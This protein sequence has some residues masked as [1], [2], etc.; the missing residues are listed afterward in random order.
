LVSLTVLYNWEVVH[1]PLSRSKIKNMWS[2]TSAPRGARTSYYRD[3]YFLISVQVRYANVICLHFQSVYFSP[4]IFL[5]FPFLSTLLP[6]SPP[7]PPSP[8]TD[9]ITPFYVLQ[10]EAIFIFHSSSNFYRQLNF[11]NY[12]VIC[13]PGSS[14]GIATGYGLV[15]PGIK[16]LRSRVRSRPKPSCWKNPQHAFLRRGSKI[17][18]PMSQLW[19][20]LKNPALFDKLRNC[21]TNSISSFASGVRC[22]SGQYAASSGGEGGKFLGDR[23]YW[24]SSLSTD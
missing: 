16:Y 14:V 5:I 3:A 23:V 2:Y 22:V 17:I 1:P 4:N 20:M 13:G 19:G 21:W 7:P 9:F 15:G 24:L 12:I 10:V 6:I 11:V 8:L 18:C